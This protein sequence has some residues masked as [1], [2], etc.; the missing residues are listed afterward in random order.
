M[1]VTKNMFDSVFKVVPNVDVF[2]L[3]DA[4]YGVVYKNIQTKCV[5]GSA[6]ALVLKTTSGLVVVEEKLN[7][8]ADHVYHLSAPLDILDMIKS[9]KIDNSGKLSPI[10]DT[11][12]SYMFGLNGMPN[13][14][15]R[16]VNPRSI[17][18][19]TPG[20]V[21]QD[22]KQNNVSHMQIGLMNHTLRQLAATVAQ[23]QYQ[24]MQIKMQNVQGCGQPIPQYGY[25]HSMQSVYP[26]PPMNPGFV[27]Q[28]FGNP[29]Q[30]PMQYPHSD[31]NC[32]P[33]EDDNSSDG[34]DNRSDK[35][36]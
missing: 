17:P 24:V 29:F 27:N 15:E 28:G 31:Q 21:N 16:L 7:L 6:R 30:N 35:K 36:D 33:K 26:Y 20:F 2:K 23:L 3:K 14:H 34:K 19:M 9:M 22:M 12:F 10:T 25:P 5:G 18:P 13:I 4:A 11:A 1:L 8:N 32:G